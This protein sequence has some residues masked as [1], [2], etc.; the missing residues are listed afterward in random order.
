MS[1]G[2]SVADLVS[3]TVLA[4]KIYKAC[5]D[6]VSE[7][8]NISSEVVTLHVVLKEVLDS[9]V[10]QPLT[11]HQ[12][13]ELGSVGKGC[14]D[15]L[16]DLDK[17]LNRYGSFGTAKGLR[18]WDRMKWGLEDVKSMRERLISNT[19]MLSAFNTAFIQCVYDP[20]FS[21][22]TTRLTG[23]YS[24][25]SQ[26][27]IEDKLN[28]LITKVG[29]GNRD[30]RISTHTLDSL[31]ADDRETWRQLRK[32]LQ[33]IGIS[34][35]AVKQHQRFI[36][37]WLEEALRVGALEGLDDDDD[38]DDE[39]MDIPRISTID[40]IV[41]TLLQWP[42]AT[43]ILLED[44]GQLPSTTP[45]TISKPL[46][47]L[48]LTPAAS[49]GM[50]PDFESLPRAAKHGDV[51]C[52]QE[53][54]NRGLSVNH[55][56]TCQGRTMLHMAARYGHGFLAR[57]LLEHG[58]QVMAT[59][60]QCRTALHLAASTPYC[61][62]I[63]LLLDHNSDIAANDNQGSTALHIASKNAQEEIVMLL[64]SKGA[65][66]AAKDSRGTTPLH[67]A[68]STGG[69]AVVEL[70]LLNGADVYEQDNI[71]RTALHRAASNGQEAAAR[72]LL[73][74]GSNG[75]TALKM[76]LEPFE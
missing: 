62:V 29:A 48:P 25:F 22:S 75:E 6:S 17:L 72:V 19:T 69:A 71:G 59:D 64:L 2:Y 44:C 37:S 46:T 73:D 8:R 47:Y 16:Q 55:H 57:L 43:P 9:L 45:N 28:M 54:L 39:R 58:A 70:L 42:A 61:D 7:F 1:F 36:I 60:K 63:E 15:V 35:Q 14:N 51:E 38:D 33:D 40:S 66:I 30:S 10:C 53:M 34:S 68:A 20:D 41:D 3:T 26:A 11:Q 31:S 24:S 13:A 74:W 52:I 18:M 76:L 49:E 32:S 67:G 65:S 4:W 5:K 56:I 50:D 27:R 12:E 21:L 23:V